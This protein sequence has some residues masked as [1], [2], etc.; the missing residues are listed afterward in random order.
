MC[1]H[2]S[3]L[4]K[5]V[6]MFCSQYFSEQQLKNPKVLDVTL[7]G[8]GHSYALLEAFDGL[9]LEGRDRDL[10]AVERSQKRLETFGSRANLEQ[11]RFSEI[12]PASFDVVLA[13]LGM[14]SFQLDDPNR[15]FALR[16]DGPLDMRMSKGQE[17]SAEQ[18]V[19]QY[20]LGKLIG[21]LKRGGVGGISASLAKRIIASRPVSSTLELRQLC[22][23][24]AMKAKSKKDIAVVCFQA[25][26]I[27]VNSEF[28]EI[29]Q[30]LSLIKTSL[31]SGGLALVISFHSLEDKFVTKAFRDWARGITPS[32]NVLEGT[33]G[34]GSLLTSKAVVPDEEELKSNSRSRSALLRVF[35]FDENK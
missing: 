15:G 20:E 21:V 13:D 24:L 25:I 30:L 9:R 29:K 18:V 1:S 26:R 35:R 33:P 5:E 2:K 10:E 27:E 14:S 31:S 17:L 6:L 8:A 11:A 19:N 16:F 22:E 23:D 28:E 7:G 12:E 3:V 32:R 4:L 34:L